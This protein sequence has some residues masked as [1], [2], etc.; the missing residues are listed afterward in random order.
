MINDK[1]RSA[2]RGEIIIDKRRFLNCCGTTPLIRSRKE[3]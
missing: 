1:I 2:A 3:K